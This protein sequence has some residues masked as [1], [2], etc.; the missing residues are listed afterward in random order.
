MAKAERKNDLV[1]WR[2]G[3]TPT[4]GPELREIPVPEDDDGRVH[5]VG[6]LKRKRGGV[7]PGAGKGGAL[8]PADELASGKP[9]STKEKM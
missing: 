2:K 7:M 6:A 1:Q 3:F 9:M 4:D 5:D 8:L